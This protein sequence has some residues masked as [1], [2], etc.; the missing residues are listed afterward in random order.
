M[1][2]SCVPFGRHGA[3]ASDRISTDRGCHVACALIGTNCEL[4]LRYGESQPAIQGVRLSLGLLRSDHPCW[5]D[6]LIRL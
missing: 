1:I 4:A 3:I 6:V 2:T 5:P